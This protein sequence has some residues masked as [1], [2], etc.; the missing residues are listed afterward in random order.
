[1]INWHL[2]A[3][4][5]GRLAR[6]ARGQWAVEMQDSLVGR[7]CGSYASQTSNDQFG[8]TPNGLF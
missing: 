6:V 4:K 2:R 3:T 1:L 7:T 8:G 5:P